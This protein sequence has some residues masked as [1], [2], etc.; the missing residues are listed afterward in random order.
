M[1]AW[2]RMAIHGSGCSTV[3]TAY[4]SACRSAI[5]GQDGSYL[6]LDL[7]GDIIDQQRTGGAEGPR[8]QGEEFSNPLLASGAATKDV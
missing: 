8:V 5:E 4:G 7:V 1:L 2:N 3:P 6:P